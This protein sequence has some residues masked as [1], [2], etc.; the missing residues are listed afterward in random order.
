METVDVEGDRYK[1]GD[2][3]CDL[4]SYM[5]GELNFFSFLHDYG[6]LIPLNTIYNNIALIL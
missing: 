4:I 6:H 3:K 1:E 2:E 5:P